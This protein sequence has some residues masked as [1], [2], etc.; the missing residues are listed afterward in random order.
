MHVVLLA[1]KKMR[2]LNLF[3]SL[4]LIFTLVL[5]VGCKEEKT[6]QTTY[7]YE[8]LV[9][10]KCCEDTNQN[11]VC[12]ENEELFKQLDL[13]QGKIDECLDEA[14]LFESAKQWDKSYNK[15]F[16]CRTYIQK[17]SRAVND[18]LETS[19]DKEFQKSW[20]IEYL[21][22]QIIDASTEFNYKFSK[23]LAD[24]NQKDIYQKIEEE[25][26]IQS[27]LGSV[28]YYL[29]EYI[30]KYP[31]QY[32]ENEVEGTL[33]WVVTSYK[34]SNQ[35]VNDF[36]DEITQDFFYKFYAQVN[37]EDSLII[38]I[39]DKLSEGKSDETEIALALLD[40]VR[41]NVEYKHDPNWMTDWVNSPRLT[42]VY[43]K[44]DCDDM[45]VL[46]VSLMARAG[47]TAELCSA[48]TDLDGSSDHLTVRYNNLI[49]EPTCTNC[50]WVAS[51]HDSINW[52]VSCRSPDAYLIETE[53]K[54]AN[55]GSYLFI[56]GKYAS[57]EIVRASFDL[58]DAVKKQGYGVQVVTESDEDF[59]LKKGNI[60]WSIGSPC[61][62]D[63][64]AEL[65][66]MSCEEWHNRNYL[67]QLGG[68]IEDFKWTVTPIDNNDS[69]G[70]QAMFYNVIQKLNSGNY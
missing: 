47:V 9:D 8:S 7:P 29:W 19:E 22:Y 66:E 42:L 14:Y 6:C 1:D 27:S 38:E 2:K 67:P 41:Q 55:Q 36:Y 53:E 32:K 64:S 15:Y 44:G 21:S 18:I 3:Y 17:A 33:N 70:I 61:V 35:I 46:L 57:S 5:I 16:E 48:D 52:D 23:A 30:Q 65:M 43:G 59:D 25:K 11:Q 39:A 63:L 4:I 10:D 54:L 45:A 12:D 40:F 58:A 62:S 49:Y 31:E 28:L 34:R 68:T 13:T 26:S 51:P 20:T 37:I 60:I 24:T 56:I 50:G 69:A